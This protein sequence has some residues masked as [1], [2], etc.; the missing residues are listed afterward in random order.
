MIRTDDP[1]RDWDRYCEAQEA[2]ME[3]LPR[4]CKCGVRLIE[5]YVYYIE[6]E[7]YCDDCV[8]RHFQ[9]PNTID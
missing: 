6:D 4:C 5:E 7:Y 2:E 9:V 8:M 1:V 3:K